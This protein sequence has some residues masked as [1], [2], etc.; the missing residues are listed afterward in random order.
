MSRRQQRLQRIF[1]RRMIGAFAVAAACGW[2][3]FLS[4]MAG[5]ITN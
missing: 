5:T 4:S 2:W 3:I 1:R